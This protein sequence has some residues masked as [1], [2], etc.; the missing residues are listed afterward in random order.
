MLNRLHR[1]NQL[2]SIVHKSSFQKKIKQFTQFYDFDE[3]P[4]LSVEH[5]F[6][7]SLGPYQIRQAASYCQMHCRANNDEFVVFECPMDVSN[8]VLTDFKPNERDLKLLMMRI[9][10]RYRSQKTHDVYVLIDIM[11]K[12]EE[13]VLEYC[14]SCQNGL[15]TVGSCSHVMSLLWFS[16]YIKH[17]YAMPR[18]AG[19][20]NDYFLDEFSSDDDDD[21]EE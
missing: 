5:L 9:K 4:Q 19:F 3:L 18:P 14:C 2:Y 11:G 8:E 7:I 17:T 13:C 20:L 15:R 21:D 1:P 6:Q 12:G 10:S 16:L